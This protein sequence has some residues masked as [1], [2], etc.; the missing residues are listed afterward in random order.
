MT[1]R[2]KS[3]LLQQSFNV[4]WIF[5]NRQASCTSRTAFVTHSRVTGWCCANLR[6]PTRR[7]DSLMYG[8]RRSFLM[9]VLP[10]REIKADHV[11]RLILLPLKLR[12]DV[13]CHLMFSSR[14]F[15]TARRDRIRNTDKAINIFYTS[16][17]F[18]TS[19]I[20]ITFCYMFHF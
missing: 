12:T 15:D 18:F 6:G 10:Y 17:L 5:D 19:N 1:H 7:S 11:A 2:F 4:F 20:C 14:L 8:E 16:Y 13:T 3:L 9:S